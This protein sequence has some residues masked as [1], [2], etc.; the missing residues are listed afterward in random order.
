MRSPIECAEFT[1]SQ[2]QKKNT[3]NLLKFCFVIASNPIFYFWFSQNCRYSQ[4]QKLTSVSCMASW[5]AASVSKFGFDVPILFNLLTSAAISSNDCFT[6]D[7]FSL[8]CNKLSQDESNSIVKQNERKRNEKCSVKIKLN[9]TI[10]KKLF[11]LFSHEIFKIKIEMTKCKEGKKLWMQRIVNWHTW[12]HQVAAASLRLMRERVIIESEQTSC[13]EMI[14]ITILLLLLLHAKKEDKLF[15][16]DLMFS[17]VFTDFMS[18]FI[19]FFNFFAHWKNEFFLVVCNN[20]FVSI[21]KILYFL[22]KLHYYR[23]CMLWKRH[24]VQCFQNKVCSAVNK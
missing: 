1:F 4:I 3:K 24:G 15:L 23:K 18:V 19:S 14:M 5:I 22:K 17:L 13:K 12:E 9:K 6:N 11:I 2:S 20:A 7:S 16:L 8:Q 10:Q 21:W